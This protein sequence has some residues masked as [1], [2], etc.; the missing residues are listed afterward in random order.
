MKTILN[1]SQISHNSRTKSILFSGLIG[2]NF[3]TIGDGYC[4]DT[5]LYD[6]ENSCCTTNLTNRHANTEDDIVIYRVPKKAI[7]EF[8]ALEKKHDEFRKRCEARE[9]KCLSTL[10]A[11]CCCIAALVCYDYIVSFL[12][13]L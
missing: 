5:S 4:A 6:V 8:E 12:K 3:L 13:S 11:T 2:F 7:K 10:A 9:E 1:N